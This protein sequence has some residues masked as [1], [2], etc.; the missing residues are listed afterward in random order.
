MAKR[1]YYEILGVS[2]GASASDIKKAYRKLALKY[3]PDKNPDD[4]SAEEKFKEAAEAYEV[5]SDD[6]K[7]QQYDR[8]G[9][10]GMRGGPGGFGGGGMDMDDIFSQFGDIFG[11][12]FGGGGG[13][14]RRM[15]GSNLRIKV[16][17][18]LEEVSEGVSKKVKV[19]KQVP[20]Q[21]VEYSDCATCHGTGQVRRVTNTILGQMQTAS[22]CNVCHGTGQSITRKP[23]GTDDMGMVREEA[24]VSL[25]IPAGVEDGMQLSV[26]GEGNGAPMGG[27]SGD[28]IVL[29]EVL[30]H[31]SFQRN[32]KNL[33]HDHY[34]SFV[35]AALG[36]TA[37]V[38]LLGGK[39]KIKIDPGTQSGKIVRLRGKGLPAVDSYGNGDLLVN[40]NVW[41]PKKLSK[42][43]TAALE[44]MRESANFQ[45]DADHGERGFFDKVRDMF[46]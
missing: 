46:S 39:A 18:T 24:V 25:D 8:F 21:G 4:A 31:E 45:P 5:L 41:T 42:D 9:H 19:F 2:K 37:E 10:E 32:G 33:H 22:T 40:L 23:S 12:A 29:V 17:L 16:K 38:P 35:D 7:R 28:L 1:D 34:I 14:R 43:E 13:R 3:H 36:S 20:A 6:T 27:V 44:Q 30:P 11:G 26:R 15:K